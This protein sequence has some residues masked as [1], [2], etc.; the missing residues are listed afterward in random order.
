MTDGRHTTEYQGVGGRNSEG[1]SLLSDTT[2]WEWSDPKPG[3]KRTRKTESIQQGSEGDGEGMWN[4]HFD[5][6]NQVGS[7]SGTGDGA[8]R[9][10]AGKHQDRG[11]AGDKTHRGHTHATELGIQSMGEGGV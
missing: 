11:L 9:L 5:T 4:S 1:R 2:R 8:M 7:G 10:M 6:Q 3:D